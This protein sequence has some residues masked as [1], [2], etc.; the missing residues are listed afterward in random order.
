VPCSLHTPWP[1]LTLYLGYFERFEGRMT[2]QLLGHINCEG[3]C[4]D[5]LSGTGRMA[6]EGRHQYASCCCTQF[7]TNHACRPCCQCQRAT[8]FCP[9]P[10]PSWWRSGPAGQQGLPPHPCRHWPP[11]PWQHARPH[12]RAAGGA[13]SMV[14]Q[15]VGQ[16]G[17]RGTQR[18]G[19]PGKQAA[20][21]AS[22]AHLFHMLQRTASWVPQGNFHLKC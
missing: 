9:C 6:R 10:C 13:G 22:W 21:M 18:E 14:G 2:V 8:R 11:A 20:G 3:P 1:A 7:P 17:R 4:W 16:T 19:G 5:Q 12:L 15:A